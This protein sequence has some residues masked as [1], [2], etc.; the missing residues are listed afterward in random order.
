MRLQV[1]RLAALN[2]EVADIV[3]VDVV[4]LFSKLV[5]DVEFWQGADDILD[6][7]ARAYR[8]V[9][10]IVAPESNGLSSSSTIPPNFVTEAAQRNLSVV[11]SG[12]PLSRLVFDAL[13]RGSWTA[14]IV[15]TSLD[16]HRHDA[17]CLAGPVHSMLALE[18]GRLW[19]SQDFVGGVEHV[20]TVEA[21][22]RARRHYHAEYRQDVG[23][24]VAGQP[25]RP[26]VEWLAELFVDPKKRGEVDARDF[27]LLGWDRPEDA[28]AH[29]QFD[30]VLAGL[31]KRPTTTT[32]Y[33]C[34]DV[35]R[36]RR[37][38]TL[39]RLR[40]LLPDG[41]HETTKDTEAEQLLLLLLQHWPRRW[42]GPRMIDLL[43]WMRRRNM[44]LPYSAV[45]PAWVGVALDPERPLDLAIVSPGLLAV[46][47]DGLTWLE[48]I[49]R[50]ALPPKTLDRL[51]RELPSLDDALR[52]RVVKSGQLN[53]V[54][55][56][57][58]PTI[59]VLTRIEERGC[60]IDVPTG[61]SSWA[62][63][64]A[65]L[66]ADFNA[67]QSA[68]TALL[69]PI[70]WLDDRQTIKAIEKKFPHLPPDEKAC[71]VADQVK[72]YIAR[73]PALAPLARARA[74]DGFARA[75]P[76]SD[77]VQSNVSS[78]HPRS[79]LQK[80]G[81]IGLHSPPLQSLNRRGVEGQLIRSALK[82]R[83]DY[84]LVG[85]DYNGFEARLAAELSNDSVLV[86]ACNDPDVYIPVARLLFNTTAPTKAERD[87]TKAA[88]L[89]IFYGQQQQ[90]FWIH[91]PDVPRTQADALYQD[92]THVLGGFISFRDQEHQGM[93]ATGEVRTVG[94]WHRTLRSTRPAELERE[95][96]NALIQSLAGDVFRRVLR[97]LDRDLRSLEAHVVH[98]AFDEVFVEAPAGTEADVGRLIVE[99][100]ERVP[101]EG[102]TPLLRRV[103]LVAKP[104]RFGD[105]WADL[106]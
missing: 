95:G 18:T 40:C 89:A 74:L 9:I 87:R 28:A 11:T 13:T 10:W 86:D 47:P 103:P 46:P 99:T 54:E 49:R 8:H 14:T 27:R 65:Q 73:T 51:S 19:R 106:I 84:K 71:P 72:R 98:H 96:F 58:G 20:A 100:M 15:T 21:V 4:A 63:F 60:A 79:T 3:I 2:E 32:G 26:L 42:F 69:G 16:D 92:I 25:G 7:C 78:L 36:A 94:G 53:L 55:E 64:G 12:E 43:Y 45:D 22:L 90:R 66:E 6:A 70:N 82:T 35:H 77:D 48:D 83:P 61:F 67:N 102:P 88:L 91:L 68:V 97:I 24:Y 76:L 29:A 17:W 23:R 85:V 56:D 41:W 33:V 81:R 37:S 93:H 34:A 75:A 31:P 39:E 57:L 30:A 44:S 59:P 1:Q 80:N 38:V 104:P 105:T 101:Y 5:T 50:E 62:A 52:D